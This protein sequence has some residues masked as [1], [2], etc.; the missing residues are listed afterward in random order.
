MS[1]ITGFHGPT[2][3]TGIRPLNSHK[4][5]IRQFF[6]VFCFFFAEAVFNH[7]SNTGKAERSSVTYHLLHNERA[8]GQMQGFLLYKPLYSAITA[9]AS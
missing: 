5:P 4:S 8:E 2:C 1:S 9:F 7:V 6:F 3:L